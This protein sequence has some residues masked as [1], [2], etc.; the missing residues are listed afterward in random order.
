MLNKLLNRQKP[1][2]PAILKP[3]AGREEVFSMNGGVL[4]GRETF[5]NPV[6]LPN[7]H[8]VCIGASGSGKTQ[9]LKGLAYALAATTEA[10]ILII[11]F[12]GDQEIQG[13]ICYAFHR[14]S[15]HG[16]NL[17]QIDLDEEG[18]GVNLAII[19]LAHSLKTPLMIG[20]NQEGV[21]IE[22]FKRT[23]ALCGIFD[24][25]PETWRKTPPTFADVR[26]VLKGHD[27]REAGKLEQKFI[28]LWEY[29]IFSRRQPDFSSDKLVRLDF[30]KLPSALASIAANSV[31]SQT[32]NAHRLNGSTT[33]KFP[34]RFLFIDEAKE[35]KASP[36]LDR[37]IAD[38][39]KFGLALI[40]A[41]QSERHLSADIIANSQTKIVLPVDQTEV[42]SVARKFRFDEYAIAALKPLNALCRFG[43]QAAEIEILPYYERET[44]RRHPAGN[45]RGAFKKT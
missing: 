40:L 6:S 21:L 8:V 30:S 27:S 2:P 12:H 3:V 18:G 16:I 43:T 5:W 13:E 42:R 33:E 41:S 31:C 19:R 35:L 22:V 10:R 38:G 29:G 37:I 17:M 39:R 15:A 32:V 28:S 7:A 20:V 24:S 44:E 34:E 25:K 26:E 11:D 9:T 36:I 23:Y 1:L 4:L 14:A 45:E